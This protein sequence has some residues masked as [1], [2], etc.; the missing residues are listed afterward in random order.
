MEDEQRSQSIKITIPCHTPQVQEE[1][2]GSSEV[3]TVA[4][5]AL[6]G[7]DPDFALERCM[8]DSK[9]PPSNGRGNILLFSR[10]S[11]MSG[12]SYHV[13]LIHAPEDGQLVR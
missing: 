11:F 8:P 9:I 12:H 13:M 2:V 6:L 4:D 5:Q 3:Q 7:K 10:T 1:H